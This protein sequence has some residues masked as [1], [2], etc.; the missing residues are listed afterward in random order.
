MKN[1]IF[2]KIIKGELPSWKVYEDKN[3]LAILTLGPV[4][5]GHTLVMPKKHYENL[6]DIPEKEAMNLMKTIKKISIPIMKAVNAQGINLGMNNIIEQK[7]MHA[8]IHIMPRFK[9]DGLVC[10]PGKKYKKE[11]M[12][13]ILKKIKKELK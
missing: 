5:P 11:K 2:C 1:C 4:N 8:H 13:E 7:I 3:T 10:W 9:S 6:F 12:D